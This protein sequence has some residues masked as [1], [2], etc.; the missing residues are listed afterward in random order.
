MSQAREL[1]KLLES[2]M[3][4]FNTISNP[5]QK[6]KSVSTTKIVKELRSMYDVIRKGSKKDKSKIFDQIQNLKRQIAVAKDIRPEV[7]QEVKDVEVAFS[8]KYGQPPSQAGF[9]DAFGM[10]PID[11]DS[12]QGRLF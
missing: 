10:N 7:T 3:D 1:I 12:G 8:R 11:S 4:M 2:Q 9:L 5:S 6:F